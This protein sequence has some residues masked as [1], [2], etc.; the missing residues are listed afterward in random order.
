PPVGDAPAGGAPATGAPPDLANSSPFR[1]TMPWYVWLLIPVALLAGF[2]I[3]TALA[4]GSA[5]AGGS[6]VIDRIK[7]L[8]AA[9]RGGPL[10]DPK[11]SW[12][13]LTSLRGR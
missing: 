10:P 1:P 8:N 2:V 9:R 4:D 7:K 11:S 6:G 12:R 13:R 5:V 3:R